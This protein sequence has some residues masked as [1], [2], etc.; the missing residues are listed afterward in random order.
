MTFAPKPQMFILQSAVPPVLPS[1]IPPCRR[2]VGV[3]NDAAS[4]D[5]SHS[6]E[7]GHTTE[8][9]HVPIGTLAL[10]VGI[11]Y[12]LEIESP[13]EGMLSA[14]VFVGWDEMIAYCGHR[15]YLQ[16]RARG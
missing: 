15:L 7:V 8:N 14:P 4:S 16:V 1:A 2:I 11:I 5:L 3:R 12:H 10:R 6:G 9:A 13:D